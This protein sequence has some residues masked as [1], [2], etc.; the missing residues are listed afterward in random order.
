MDPNFSALRK[1]SRNLDRQCDWEAVTN[2]PRYAQY[3]L[4]V[5]QVEVTMLLC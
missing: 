3:L 2:Q 1:G 5:C 4:L